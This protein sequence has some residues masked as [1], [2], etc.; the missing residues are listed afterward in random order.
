MTKI[1]D[2]NHFIK[3]FTNSGYLKANLASFS[4][5]HLLFLTPYT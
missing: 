3:K 2:L 4:I 1:K 5:Q